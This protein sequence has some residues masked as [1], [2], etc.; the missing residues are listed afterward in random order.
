MCARQ[1][2]ESPHPARSLGSSYP[3]GQDDPD[4]R[5][6]GA[7]GW[8]D[9]LLARDGSARASR[10]HAREVDMD[11]V[12]VEAD[13]VHLSPVGGDERSEDLVTDP[14]D[15]VLRSL[16]HFCPGSVT[17]AALASRWHFRGRRGRRWWPGVADPL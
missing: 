14:L 16:V 6:R 12:A 7:Q 11:I 13:Q 8:Q 17:G 5:R 2:R 3:G 10:A 1:R 15:M 9:H 4:L